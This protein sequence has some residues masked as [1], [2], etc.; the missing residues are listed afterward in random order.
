MNKSN[1]SV[2]IPLNAV[3][4]NLQDQTNVAL[5]ARGNLN[6]TGTGPYVVY[7][8]LTDV[9]GQGLSK[10]SDSSIASWAQTVSQ[11]NDGYVNA[12]ALETLFKIQH[13]LV[14]KQMV[15]D[16]EIIVTAS[17]SNVATVQW[18]LMPFS[19][20]SVHIASANPLDTP[21]IDPKLFVADVD[22]TIQT[23]ILRFGRSV[24]YTK[25]MSDLVSQELVPGTSAVP[26]NATDAEWAPFVKASSKS[27]LHLWRCLHEY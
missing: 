6:F 7:A 27:Y 24:F 13:D 10:V 18:G 26:L 1:V 23:A 4:E 9:F 17:S 22:L 19:R 5:I 25:P 2:R 14:F 8:N 3:G 11:A 21:H 15:S 16:A 20:G 12:T